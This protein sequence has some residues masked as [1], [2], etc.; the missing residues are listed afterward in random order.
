LFWAHGR[1]VAHHENEARSNRHIARPEKRRIHER[2]LHVQLGTRAPPS[3]EGFPTRDSGSM[4]FRK[5]NG[6]L[7]SYA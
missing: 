2:S 1:P 7:F 6:N 4:D 5:Q 3:G